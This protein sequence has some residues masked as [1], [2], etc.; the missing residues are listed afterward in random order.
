MFT[1]LYGKS[2]LCQNSTRD[3]HD[4]KLGFMMT[5]LGF[6]HWEVKPLG[7]GMCPV[8]AV[9]QHG[10]LEKEREYG[11]EIGGRGFDFPLHTEEKP[12]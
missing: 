9:I 4:F 12:S 7:T 5:C 2:L 1:G 11:G 6:P 10:H 8:S 3:S